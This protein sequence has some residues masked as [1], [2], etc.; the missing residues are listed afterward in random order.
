MSSPRNHSTPVFTYWEGPFPLV[1]RLCVTS[2]RKSLGERHVHVTPETLGEFVDLDE[3]PSWVFETNI[4][5]RSDMI[6]I[7][8]LRKYGGWWLD[9]DILLRRDP[10]ELIVD[11]AR[12]YIWKEVVS[13]QKFPGYGACAA[14]LRRCPQTLVSG[15]PPVIP[16]L[17][18]MPWGVW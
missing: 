10:S 5:Y 18:A 4:G 7:F 14:V 2:I 8:L 3:F 6:R 11:P 9:C 13:E 12:T 16:R 1:N 17:L 15:F